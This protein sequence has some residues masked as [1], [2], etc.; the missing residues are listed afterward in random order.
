M[1]LSGNGE[2]SL[3]RGAREWHAQLGRL[4][5]DYGASEMEDIEKL[6]S[7]PYQ[8]PKAI[9]GQLLLPVSRRGKTKVRHWIKSVQAS[10]WHLGIG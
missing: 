1:Q 6:S 3:D 4:G 9:K 10:F 5:S 7:D 2:R 8:D